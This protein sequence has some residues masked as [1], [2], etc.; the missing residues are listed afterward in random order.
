LIGDQEPYLF[1]LQLVN[2]FT[3][4]PYSMQVSLGHHRLMFDEVLEAA[5]F[6]VLELGQSVRLG[7][8]VASWYRSVSGWTHGDLGHRR[9][10]C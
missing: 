7:V 9:A 2:Q 4:E 1:T 6:P 5:Y 8:R 3:A 10:G